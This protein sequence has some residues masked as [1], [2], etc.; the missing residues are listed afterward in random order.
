[1]PLPS[2]L[3][4]VQDI[5][6][7]P[8]AAPGAAQKQLGMTMQPQGQQNWCWAAAT[9]TVS[10]FYNKPPVL[11]QC[12]VASQ[13]LGLSC[14]VDPLPAPQTPPWECDRTYALDTALSVA[15]HLRGDA[16]DGQVPFQTIKSEIDAGHPICCHI[17]WGSDTGH[18]IAIVGY[19]DGAEADV[20]IEDSLYGAGKPA[21]LPYDVFRQSYQ[22]GGNWDYTYLTQ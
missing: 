1:M 9:A 7:S 21:L 5:P 20:V 14:S 18:F 19:S 16:V 8:P 6:G 17:S 11:T 15:G 3:S 4:N 22:Q 10:A 2:F 13:C 12:D